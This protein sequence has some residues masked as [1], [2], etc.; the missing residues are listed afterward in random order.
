MSDWDEAI[1]APHGWQC[2]I[3]KRV[4][5]PAIPMCLYCSDNNRT[6]TDDLIM[7]KDS[8]EEWLKARSQ[9]Y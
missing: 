2:P 3:C 9:K 6:K 5:S 7:K 8:V 1:F 4:Y